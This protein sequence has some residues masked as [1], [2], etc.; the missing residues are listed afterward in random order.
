MTL[1]PRQPVPDLTLPLVGSSEFNLRTHGASNFSL[2]VF[3]RGLHCPI[4]RRYLTELQEKLSQ[5]EAL[6]VQPVAIS[7]DTRERA[8]QAVAEWGL[9][10]LP[11]AWGL[12]IAQAREWG[13][14]ISSPV[15]PTDPPLFNEPGFVLVRPDMTL[16]YI[17][18]SNS[19]WG[20]PPITE[21]LTAVDNFIKNAVP[22]RGDA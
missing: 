12:P 1:K 5:F 10:R 22:P 7:S 19:P 17:A 13:L 21:M 14:Y 3:Y 4:C 6:G 9:N 20:R 15:R 8:Q 18:V 16:Q 11:V 2:L